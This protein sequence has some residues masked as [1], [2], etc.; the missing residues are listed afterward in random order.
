L[1]RFVDFII[2]RIADGLP[3]PETL[4]RLVRGVLDYH[5]GHLQDDAT[6]LLVEWHGDAPERLHL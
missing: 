4:R 6:V 2:R 1:G 5:D 3:P